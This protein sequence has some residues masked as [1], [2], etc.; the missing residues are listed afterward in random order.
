MYNFIQMGNLI[1]R[2]REERGLTI[3]EL[4]ELCDLSYRC[5]SNI[6]RGLTNSKFANIVK[7]FFVL[8]KNL[9]ELKQFMILH[10]DWLEVRKNDTQRGFYKNMNIKETINEICSYREPML[11]NERYAYYDWWTKRYNAFPI[12]PK[13][14]TIFEIEYINFC[15][16]CG[17]R[18]EWVGYNRTKVRYAGERRQ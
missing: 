10:S 18:L 3:E 9:N 7:I 2:Y 15:S 1:R 17:Q 16:S 8:G 12:C 13:C 5:I 6:E 11:V 14:G 4:A